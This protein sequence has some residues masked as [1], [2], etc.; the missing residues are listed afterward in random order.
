MFFILN[1]QEFVLENG[2]HV[3]NDIF[4]GSK[5]LFDL[6]KK[7]Q[8]GLVLMHTPGP[9]KTMQLKTNTYKNVVQDIKKIFQKKLKY[10]DKIGISKRK[11]WFDPG[12][13]FGKNLKQNLK[14]IKN[15]K[16]FKIENYGLLL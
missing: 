10:I 12:I 8:S 7:Y 6:T 14:I 1:E 4:G 15:L 2:A 16:K 9:P 11:V 13:G 3:I 5:D